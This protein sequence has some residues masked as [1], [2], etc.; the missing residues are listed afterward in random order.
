MGLLNTSIESTSTL[1]WPSFLLLI[2]CPTPTLFSASYTV[3]MEPQPQL[4]VVQQGTL[5]PSRLNTEFSTSGQKA[6]A[7]TFAESSRAEMPA[8]SQP[9]HYPLTFTLSSQTICTVILPTFHLSHV[10]SS[11]STSLRKERKTRLCHTALNPA[12]AFNISSWPRLHSPVCSLE[13]L[14]PCILKSCV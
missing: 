8:P 3:P 12:P 1:T 6:T 10:L 2:P 9:I 13:L 7:D 4:L 11:K 5:Q 14:A